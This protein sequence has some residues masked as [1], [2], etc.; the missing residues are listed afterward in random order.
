MALSKRSLGGNFRLITRVSYNVQ[1]IYI[2]AL[3]NHK[4]DDRKEWMK[5]A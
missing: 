3:L 5:W 1:R 2:K 4:G